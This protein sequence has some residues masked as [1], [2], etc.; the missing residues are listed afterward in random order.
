[1]PE[2]VILSHVEEKDSDIRLDRWFKRYYP[3]LRHG[4]LERLLRGK[5]IRVNGKKATADQHLKT[6]DEI[7]IPPFDEEKMHINRDVSEKDAAFIRSLVIYKDKDVIVLNKP[8]G[9]AVQGG[10]K[11]ERHIDGMLDALSEGGER[12]RLVHRLDKETSGVLV[13]ARTAK[14]ASFLA[15]AFQTK[16]A[17]KVYW[18][19]VLGKPV[20]NSGK[21]TAPLLKKSGQGGKEM[22]FV[23]PDGQKAQSLYQVIDT[24]GGKVSWLALMPLTGRT[25]QLR[26]HCQSIGTPILGD[27]KYGEKTEV[28]HSE[29][30]SKFMQLHARALQIPLPSGKMLKITAQIPHHMK[31]SFDFFGFSDKDNREPFET[32]EKK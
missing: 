24:A 9:L 28:A 30:F 29:A 18:A 1:M 31:N 3:G 19:L 7:R 25:H 16:A 21:I 15:Q 27:V 22:V 17:R 11:T 26:V 6:G 13:L 14:A 12:P 10:S 5:N 4:A 32:F 2:K 8:A 20:K 23:D